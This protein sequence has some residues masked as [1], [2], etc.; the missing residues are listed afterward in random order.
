MMATRVVCAC[1]RRRQAQADGDLL[2]WPS[3]RG[4]MFPDL[5]LRKMDARARYYAYGVRGE[6]EHADHTGEPF[7]FELCPWCGHELP[8][9]PAIIKWRP[10]ADGG[11]D[12]G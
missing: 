5:P 6:F 3:A 7:V 9:V 1:D 2:Y 10:Q 4:W 12:G 8:G 11:E